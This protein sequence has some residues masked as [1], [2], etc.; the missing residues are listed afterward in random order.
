D[1]RRRR[2]ESHNA[3][4]RRR[5]ENI[6]D[7]IQE[8]GALLPDGL[9]DNNRSNKGQ[10]LTNSVTYIRYLQSIIWNNIPNCQN[11]RSIFP[12]NSGSAGSALS[13]EAT[14][15]AAMAMALPN[16]TSDPNPHP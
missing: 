13:N 9:I 1:K 14:N 5:R 10:I 12:T 4:E 7:K 16:T 3:V 15:F 8:L 11:D 2:R 6:N